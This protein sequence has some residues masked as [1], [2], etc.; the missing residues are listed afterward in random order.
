MT[1]RVG[2]LELG[3][4]QE[5]HKYWTWQ[6]IGW[7]AIAVLLLAAVAGLFGK[8]PVANG[9]AQSADGSLQVEY[10]R[11]ARFQSPSTLRILA[12]E[13]ATASGQLEVRVNRDYFRDVEVAQIT[14]E[15]KSTRA[16]AQELAFIFDV[17]RGESAEV[18]FQLRPNAAGVSHL[19]VHLP[20]QPPLSVRQFIYP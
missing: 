8:G 10:A 16:G 19:R 5:A 11:F 4:E 2:D 12:G 7:A 17:A 15:P 13:A 20:D 3:G 6:R 18:H 14:P 9:S 1:H